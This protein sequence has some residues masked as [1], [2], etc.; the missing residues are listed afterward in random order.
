MTRRIAGPIASFLLVSAVASPLLAQAQ[1]LSGLNPDVLRL[2]VFSTAFGALFVLLLWRKRLP[3][4]PTTRR[5]L[6][7]P[8]LV[9]MGVAVLIAGLLLALAVAQQAPWRPPDMSKLG[10]PLA[11]VLIVQLVGAAA[12][13]IGWRGL[14]QPLLETRLRPWIAALITGV[15]FAVGHFYMA[16][17]VSPL[18]FALFVL[19][20]VGLSAVLAQ[21][22]VG[23]AL[24]S[25]VL[26]ASGLHFLVNMV[27]FLLFNDGDGSPRYFADLALV[28][29]I[30]GAVALV[31]LARRAAPAASG[32]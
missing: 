29:G 1:S 12:E 10:A 16:F 25:R 30:C 5:D 11:V 32:A 23:Y 20:A 22:T 26:I 15:L 24:A 13:E 21:V 27:T 9:T 31:L 6:A 14:V 28:F 2:T 7:R 3:L 4:P 19:G 17:A 8:L 18:S